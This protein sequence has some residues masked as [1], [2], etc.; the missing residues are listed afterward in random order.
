MGTLN[1]IIKNMASFALN[2]I[3]TPISLTH[4]ASLYVGDLTTDVT[5]ALLFEI[6]NA[7]GPV[8]SIRVCRDAVTRRSLGYAYINF[9]NIVD[10]ERTL[11][12]MN[13]ILIR[14]RP[15]RIMWSQRDPSLRKSGLGNV[16]VKNLDKTIDNKTL[17]DT[18]SMFGNI[19]SCK[20]ASDDKGIS[21]GY[22]FVHYTQPEAA[23]KAIQKVDG[24][25]IAEK[26]VTVAQFIPKEQRKVGPQKF[27][28]VYIQK[29]PKSWTEENL[30]IFAERIGPVNSV[31]VPKN[32]K[33][34]S[35]GFGFANYPNPDD[36]LIAVDE[37]N[38]KEIGGEV[39]YVSRAMKKL[40]RER[41]LKERY[42]KIKDERLKKFGN[43]NLYVKYLNDSMD[44]ASLRKE[45]GRFGKITSVKVMID[46]HGR[47]KGFGFICFE[48]E[49]ES[50]R[51][52]SEMNNKLIDGKPLYVAFAQRKEVRRESLAKERQKKFSTNNQM[53]KHSLNIKKQQSFQQEQ[54]E[55][56]FSGQQKIPQQLTFQRT[57]QIRGNRNPNI[58]PTPM[59]RNFGPTPM[60]Y[61][62][63]HIVLGNSNSSKISNS[64]TKTKEE[65]YF[66]IKKRQLTTTVNLE[67][68]KQNNKI[69]KI[70]NE[71]LN[72]NSPTQKKQILG[73]YIFPLIQIREPK[74][75]GK[76]TGMLLEMDNSELLHLLENEKALIGKIN[77]ALMV[78]NQDGQNNQ[79]N[80]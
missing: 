33:G 10:A 72:S 22:G 25:V 73:E 16:F 44:D 17:Y 9:H 8:A 71:I 15:C 18:F 80:E 40:E 11:D 64:H 35:K 74:L 56:L 65:T 14:G 36:A 45:F 47:S 50:L 39:I 13:Y 2:P 52:L 42:E 43:V 69:S 54:H 41:F 49:D 30:K 63:Q 29:I 7:V 51:A 62:T 31:C 78:L 28:N 76:I 57:N 27:T 4:S 59:M 75:A 19:L 53:F 46:A 32:E 12:T 20:V 34:I 38:G 79:T 6:F 70:N 48:K 3:R 60:S 5:E 26:T 23:E 67:T 1:F 24:M 77:E 37:L 66:D 61:P 21:L 68:Q 55:F 58:P